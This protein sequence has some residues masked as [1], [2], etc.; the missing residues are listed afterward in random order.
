M[1]T[2]NGV[3]YFT[4]LSFFGCFYCNLVANIQGLSHNPIAYRYGKFEEKSDLVC[5][6]NQIYVLLW[7]KS[8]K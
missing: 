5:F 1:M 6:I 4:N 2:Y 3:H 7:K 8:A